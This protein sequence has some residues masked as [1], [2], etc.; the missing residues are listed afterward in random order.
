[1]YDHLENLLAHYVADLADWPNPRPQTTGPAL[2]VQSLQIQHVTDH[3]EDKAAAGSEKSD[4]G[5]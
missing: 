5:K 1:M 3:E 4:S 2:A